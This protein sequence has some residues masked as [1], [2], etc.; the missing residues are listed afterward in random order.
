MKKKKVLIALHII[1]LII[2][3]FCGGLWG[4]KFVQNEIRQNKEIFELQNDISLLKAEIK[5][6]NNSSKVE[7]SDTA[8]NYLALGNSIT[9]HGGADY[10][11]NEIGMAASSEEKDYV[12]LISSHLKSLYGELCMNVMNYSVWEMQTADRAETYQLIETYLDKRLDLVTIQLSENVNDM[13]TF[14]ADFEELI[15]YV[16]KCAPNA[17]IIIIDDFWSSD[18]KSLLK[19]KAAN[20]TGADFVSLDSIKGKKEYQCGM[21]TTVYD[22]EGKAHIVNHDGVA[23]H[24]GDKGMKYIAD[25]VISA[26]E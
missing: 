9:L 16:R 3:T 20:N 12:H 19:E 18:D 25:S 10:W 5:E 26:L 2:I 6:L 22:A 24:P 15:R 23:I 4:Y 14:E 8:F 11:W 7:Y 21:N 17:Q 13:T 1:M